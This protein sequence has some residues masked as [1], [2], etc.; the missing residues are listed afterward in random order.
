MDEFEADPKLFQCCGLKAEETKRK[1]KK[2]RLIYVAAGHVMFH[3][4]SCSGHE[5]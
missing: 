1:E 4:S 5:L 2:N 3:P